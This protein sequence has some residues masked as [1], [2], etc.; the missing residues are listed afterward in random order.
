M[1]R[2]K[3]FLTAIAGVLFS[4]WMGPVLSD[5]SLLPKVHKQRGSTYMSGGVQEEQ[6]KAMGKV[7]PRYPIQ[8]V[9]HSATSEADMSS[10]KV[11]MR[12]VSGNALLE[13]QS[14]GPHFF[15]NPPAS[16]RYTFDIEYNGEKQSVTKDL[17]GRRYLMLEFK[18]GG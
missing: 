5:D 11:T 10:V 12:D 9:F 17:V 13:A 7:A 18:F 2:I 14:E 6:R 8:L 4:L 15:I 1:K 3:L 16:G